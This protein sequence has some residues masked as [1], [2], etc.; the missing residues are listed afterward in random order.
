MVLYDMLSIVLACVNIPLDY[1]RFKFGT[2]IILQAFSSRC[3]LEMWSFKKRSGIF[4][5]P[6]REMNYGPIRYWQIYTIQQI[7]QHVYLITKEETG[8]NY[9]HIMFCACRALHFRV[10]LSLP[11]DRLFTFLY[12]KGILSDPN[13]IFL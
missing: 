2:Q 4:G 3:V 12:I 10:L 9:L 6:T 1:K 13:N 11:I 5:R 8:I 7:Y